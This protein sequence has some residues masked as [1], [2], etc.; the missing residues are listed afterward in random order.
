VI[1]AW[2]LPQLEEGKHIRE[3]LLL[4][5]SKIY[6]DQQDY[7]NAL[8]VLKLCAYHPATEKRV[9]LLHQ[10]GQTDRC[11]EELERMLATP[12]NEEELLFATDFFQRWLFSPP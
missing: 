8:E 12:Y 6:K 7:A 10:L 1:N 3:E 5:F 9:R 2:P 4:K 11:L